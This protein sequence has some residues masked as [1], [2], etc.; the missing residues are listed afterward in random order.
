VR[1]AGAQALFAREDGD[2]RFVERVPG[3][4]DARAI[5]RVE[6]LRLPLAEGGI[7]RARVRVE[8]RLLGGATVGRFLAA[9]RHEVR[10]VLEPGRTTLRFWSESDA[11]AEILRRL[12]LLSARRAALAADPATPTVV[13]RYGLGSSPVLRDKR[14]GVSTGRVAQVLGGDLDLL[15]AP[16]G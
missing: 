11:E 7:D 9:P 4:R 12:P 16:A 3:R 14:T 13:R 8:Q 2:H 6:A 5:V 1:G 10:L 15:R